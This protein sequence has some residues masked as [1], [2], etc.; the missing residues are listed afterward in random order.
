M[1]KIAEVRLLSSWNFTIWNILFCF[2]SQV[3][4]QHIICWLISQHRIQ[5][6]HF[7]LVYRCFIWTLAE[8]NVITRNDSFTKTMSIFVSTSGVKVT[9]LNKR[10]QLPHLFIVSNIFWP[11]SGHL[12][13]KLYTLTIHHIRQHQQN[14]QYYNI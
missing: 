14:A 5:C 13:R 4:L 2:I 10:I 6:I 11:L 9:I 3:V 8:W 7:V 1:W 12:H